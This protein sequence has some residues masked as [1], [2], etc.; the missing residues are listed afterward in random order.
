VSPTTAM[1]VA[2]RGICATSQNRET[3]PETGWLGDQDSNLD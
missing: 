2:V 3:D 1:V